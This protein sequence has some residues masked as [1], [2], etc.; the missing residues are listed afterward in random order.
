MSPTDPPER[1]GH[2][3]SH[4]MLAMAACCIPMILIVALVLF[5]VI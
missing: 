1:E 3:T 2:G 4:G 5:K